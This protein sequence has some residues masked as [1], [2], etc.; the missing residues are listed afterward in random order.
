[1]ILFYIIGFLNVLSA[2]L[3]WFFSPLKITIGKIIFKK[4]LS[5]MEFDDFLFIKNKFIGELLS[6]WICCS[7]W[8]SLLVGILYTL[9]LSLPFFWPL[10]TFSTY[11]ALCYIY[12]VFVKK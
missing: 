6:C 8:L 10:L 2:L 9:T 11:P 1:M 3:L 4:E 12:Y 7:F 5:F